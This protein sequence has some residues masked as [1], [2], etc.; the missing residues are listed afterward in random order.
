M[1]LIK[2]Q[3]NEEG[4]FKCSLNK[5]GSGFSNNS[6]WILFCAFSV[7][8]L[9][10]FSGVY[11]NLNTLAGYDDALYFNMAANIGLLNWL[12]NYHS[13]LLSKMPGYA[14][15]LIAAIATRLPYMLVL[16]FCYCIAV[17]FLLYNTMWMFRKTKALS[18]LMGVVL[19]FNP[20]FVNESRIYRDQFIVICF[21]IFV[22]ALLAMF[23]PETKRSTKGL[24]IIMG[25]ISFVGLGFLFYTREENMLYYGIFVLAG[26]FLL[27][28]RTRIQSL[29]ENLYL[30]V[31]GIA[32]IVFVG[33]SISM[34][35]YINY[36]RFTVCEKISA[37]YT[38]VMKAFQLV[39]DPWQD[40]KYPAISPSC[41]KISAIAQKVPEFI[42][43]A[44]IMCEPNNKSF[45]KVASYFNKHELKIM[46]PDA[47]IIPPSHFEWFWIASVK[48]AGYYTNAESVALF[49]KN[50][51]A[52]ITKAIETGELR[53]RKV[54]SSAGTYFIVK[55]ELVSIIRG[56]PQN[57][58]TLLLSPKGYNKK[59]TNVAVR[60]SNKQRNSES[61]LKEWQ[62]WLKAKCLYEPDNDQMLKAQQ[63]L[64]N[65]FWNAIVK[66]FSL[67]L[68][69]LIHLTTPVAI[70]AAIIAII[71]KKWEVVFPLLL[72]LAG[73]IA[74]FI[75]LSAIDVVV[76]YKASHIRYF[77]PSYYSIIIAAF[78]AISF[79]LSL[80]K[81]KI[82]Q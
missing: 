32:G 52:Q 45:K 76:G 8:F 36:G 66:L 20:V 49:Y 4:F 17:A 21:L 39:D 65:K 16:G 56:L 28:F 37:P 26:L 23:N 27:I 3:A 81:S 57:Y 43:V 80:L 48:K 10:F 22:G 25:I 79:L 9:Y 5:L 71:K 78:V 44:E 15:F 18:L 77:L 73:Y 24:R 51:A 60:T 64:F 7:L 33:L 12:G 1:P 2:K 46:K 47:D 42:E 62:K 58:R 82:S 50:L 59:Y 31:C 13:I 35:N 69:P 70:M 41:N 34:L 63:T 14:I 74:H 19:L 11:V 53:K 6:Y 40:E 55:D 29:R 72:L 61:K 68:V 75:L 67:S 38:T 30:I 54:L